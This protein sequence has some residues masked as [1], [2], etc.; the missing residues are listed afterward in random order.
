MASAVVKRLW[1]EDGVRVNASLS[2]IRR[3]RRLLSSEKWGGRCSSSW[4]DEIS[5]L[6]LRQLGR[7]AIVAIVGI[8]AH[9]LQSLFVTG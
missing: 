5:K 9:M 8:A 4:D 3:C 2:L 7:V 1:L 6:R